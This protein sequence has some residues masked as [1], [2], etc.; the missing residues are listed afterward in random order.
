MLVARPFA[1]GIKGG[2]VS[3]SLRI[4]LL[5][6]LLCVVLASVACGGG[7]DSPPGEGDGTDQETVASESPTPS[8]SEADVSASPSVAAEGS[9]V[10]VEEVEEPADSTEHYSSDNKVLTAADFTSNPPATGK[11]RNN[12]LQAG[13]IYAEPVDLGEAVH[14]LEHGAVIYWT[15]GLPEESLTELEE[16]A[17]ALFAEG[18]TSLIIAENPEMDVPFAMSAWGHVQ[19]CTEVDPAAIGEFTATYYASGIEGFVACSGKAR[20]LFACKDE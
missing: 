9:C 18:Y 5:A 3:R 13:Q 10:P 11:H 2:L 4:A 15:N 16:A 8:A 17:N 20:K 19:W 1:D 7:D 14:S 12:T 6:T